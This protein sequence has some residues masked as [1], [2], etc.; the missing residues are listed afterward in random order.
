MNL[1]WTTDWLWGVPLIAFTLTC[2]V[3]VV[4]GIAVL[5]ENLGM[6]VGRRRLGRRNTALLA[7]AAI[8]TV[9]LALPVLHGLE[10]SVW[11]AAY[12]LLGAFGTLSD[13]MLYS[14]D[15]MTTRGS[16]GLNL[17]HQWKLMG[18]LESVNGVLLFGIS[19]AFL[20]TAINRFW[21]R[22]EKSEGPAQ[23][24]RTVP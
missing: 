5:L 23:L 4:I 12:L 18:A 15:S 1:A 20:A 11:A 19:T 16:P 17:A 9:G 8:G 14:M 6:S 3:A 22:I 21:N 24:Q 13:A 10:A 7:T 2:H